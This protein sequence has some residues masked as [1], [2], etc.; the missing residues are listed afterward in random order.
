MDQ[1]IN[2]LVP[3]LRDYLTQEGK[4]AAHEDAPCPCPPQ[5]N[6]SDMATQQYSPPYSDESIFGCYR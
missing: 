5:E 6:G 3:R 1:V 4:I 2:Y